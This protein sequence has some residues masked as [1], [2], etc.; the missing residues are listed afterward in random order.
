VNKTRFQKNRNRNLLGV[1]GAILSIFGA[2]GAL[3]TLAGRQSLLV[4]GFSAVFVVIGVV[5]IA[6]A[7]ED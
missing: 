2:I 5:L 1:L 6:F 4:L 7:L 3:A